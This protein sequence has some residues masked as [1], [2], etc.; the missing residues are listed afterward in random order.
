MTQR[1]DRLLCCAVAFRENKTEALPIPSTAE[2]H[3]AMRRYLLD[4][5]LHE[6]RASMQTCIAT[7]TEP[8]LHPV[9]IDTSEPGIVTSRTQKPA[10]RRHQTPLPPVVYELQTNPPP[11]VPRME[12]REAPIVPAPTS[13]EDAIKNATRATEKSLLKVHKTAQRDLASEHAN[14]QKTQARADKK[15]RLLDET[16]GERAERLQEAKRLKEER[17]VQKESSAAAQT[18]TAPEPARPAVES[19]PSRGSH[20]EDAPVQ[21]EPL[22]IDAALEQDAGAEVPHHTILPAPL[23][24]R[25]SKLRYFSTPIPFDRHLSALER[26]VPHKD[27][28]ATL[29]AGTPSDGVRIIQGPPGTGKTRALAGCLH[30]IDEF[31]RIL[32]CA[33]TNVGACNLYARVLSM[34]F[35]AAL[36][37]PSSRIPAGTPVLSQD[38]CARIVCATVSTRAGPVLDSQEFQVVL[39]DE[40]AQC[41]EAWIWAVIR[42]E[43][44]SLIMAGDVQQLPALVSSRGQALQYD[45]SLM[46]RLTQ[47]K[48]PC[49]ELRV[50]RRMHPDIVDFPNQ[51]FY[52]GQLQTAY[53]GGGVLGTPPY[54]LC[55]HTGAESAVGT[56]YANESEAAH[57]V[58]IANELARTHTNVVIIAAYQAQCRQILAMSPTVPVHTID[59]FQGQ[60][61]DAVVVSIVRSGAECGFWSDR[62][63]LVVA[64]TRAKH[65]LRVVGCMR[66]WNGTLGALYDNAQTRNLVVD[67]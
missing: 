34:G 10:I 37:I 12:P 62:R 44:H 52:G 24:A 43:V 14:L 38:P 54:L 22:H 7:P 29:I 11:R 26:A 60:E 32:L 21:L 42:P 23:R 35:Q 63:R 53:E 57:C 51:A 67:V 8:Y 28:E 40:A 19:D 48:Y 41:M 20:P 49:T 66:S 55:R 45:R 5:L 47:L 17:R 15:Q 59:S 13:I 30:Q 33:P 31:D 65:A 16:S 64:L 18:P 1:A 36:L 46:Q 50:Q 27:I 9:D 58:G 6:A 2:S 56:S 25:T 61:A 39:V 4:A 3:G